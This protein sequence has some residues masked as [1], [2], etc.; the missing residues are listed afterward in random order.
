MFREPKQ[1][2]SSSSIMGQPLLPDLLSN[3]TGVMHLMHTRELVFYLAQF[4]GLVCFA[5]HK[6]WSN[7][8]ILSYFG[9]CLDFFATVFDNTDQSKAAV[10]GYFQMAKERAKE[11][12]AFIPHIC[13][14]SSML[15]GQVDADIHNLIKEALLELRQQADFHT[16]LTPQLHADLQQKFGL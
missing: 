7:R 13:R 10:R 5:S 2:I 6:S 15:S 16:V 8:Q 9:H 11:L 14:A 1:I 4:C 12:T 3:L